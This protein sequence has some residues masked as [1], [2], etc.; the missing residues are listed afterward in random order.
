MKI[1]K[2]VA[3]IAVDLLGLYIG[4]QAASAI[5]FAF[6]LWLLS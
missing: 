4:H 6:T 2:T 3:S 5:V 1:L